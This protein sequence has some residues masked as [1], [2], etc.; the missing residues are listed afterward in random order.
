MP[1]RSIVA[2]LFALVAA[3]VCVRLGFWQLDRL[4]ERRA[5][6][7]TVM[8]RAHAE[9]V[10]VDELRADTTG[11]R[12]RRVRLAGQYDFEHEIA[13]TGRSRDGS[14]GVHLITPLLLPDSE[15]AVLVNR[16]WV[17]SPDAATVDFARWRTSPDAEGVAYVELFPEPK[18]GSA[19]SASNPR[20]VRW[21]D[22]AAVAG[23]V[24]YAVAPYYVVLLPDSAQSLDA[25]A[26]P[27]AGAYGSAGGGAAGADAGR[28]GVAAGTEAG[29]GSV[30]GAPTNPADA[31]GRL[32]IPELGDGPHLN[33]AV[34]WFIFASIAVIGVTVLL[35]SEHRARSR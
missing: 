16:G 13:L 11:L 28:G 6:N 10:R 31:P 7:A 35:V 32:V 26:A 22:S 8:Q 23:V 25:G 24:P 5:H 3:A 34:Q 30:T 9:P 21:I 17:Y 27:R 4:A 1:L 2:L 20:A 19:R 33:Y 18:R 12:Y 15:G 29:R 14:P